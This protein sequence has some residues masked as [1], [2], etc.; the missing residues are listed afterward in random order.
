MS[1]PQKLHESWQGVDLL[2]AGYGAHKETKSQV[3]ENKPS[4]PGYGWL[5]ERGVPARRSSHQVE[6]SR[7]VS[8]RS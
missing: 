4:A 1:L 6:A 7:H 2:L 8:D 5:N 3:R